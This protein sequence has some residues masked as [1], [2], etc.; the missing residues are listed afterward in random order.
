M[1]EI[2]AF[3][4]VRY[5]PSKVDL[6][7]VVAPP[8]DVIS[9]ED[10][11]FFY[12]LSDHNVVRLILGREFETDTGENNRYTRAASFFRDWLERGILIVEERPSIYLYEQEFTL[13]GG[14]PLRRRG[15]IALCRLEEF[16][17]GGVFPHE[18]TFPK[19]KEDRLNLLRACRANFSQ[20]FSIYDDPDFR[21]ERVLERE[22]SRG[23]SLEVVD[24]DGIKNRLHAISDPSVISYISEHMRQRPIFIADGHHRYETA[25]AFRNEMRA[26]NPRNAGDAPFDYTMMMFVAMQ[27]PGLA[28]I[29][30]HR[31]VFGLSRERID[32]MFKVLGAHFDTFP[33]SDVGAMID[34]M[35]PRANWHIIGMCTGDGRFYTFS[36]RDEGI[37]DVLGDRHRSP[38]WRRLDVSIL[39]TLILREGLGL[40]EEDISSERNLMYTKDARFAARWVRER[41]GRLAFLL[42]PTRVEDVKAIASNLERMPPKSTYFYPKLLSGLVMNKF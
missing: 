6:S 34:Y 5:D 21:I 37:L 7:K 10:K 25:L 4:G 22:A 40:S 38:R 27:D 14:M 26:Q 31:L 35:R 9:E 12:N 36:L 33:H 20:V 28:I 18:E 29:S 42:N 23:Y 41:E 16:H 17:E 30:T 8:Y 11:E 15:F 13:E 32:R 24:R 2:K 39:H 19:P 3:R 1:A